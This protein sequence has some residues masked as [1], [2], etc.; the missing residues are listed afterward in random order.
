MTVLVTWCAA[1]LL[2]LRE[3]QCF[4]EP[5]SGVKLPFDAATTKQAGL[6][7]E[8]VIISPEEVCILV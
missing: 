2:F 3:I 7:L 5:S 1:L 6:F 8:N 4:Q